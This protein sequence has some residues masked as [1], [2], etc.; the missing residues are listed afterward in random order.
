MSIDLSYEEL[1][2]RYTQLA[3]AMGADL[4]AATHN[5]CIQIATVLNRVKTAIV[6]ERPEETGA[7]FICGESDQKDDADGLPDRIMICPAH[8]LNGFAVYKKE[9][10]W[11]DFSGS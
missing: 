3:E 1:Q 8:G 9:R 6:H 11:K 2:R 4:N 10:N 5:D 7:Y